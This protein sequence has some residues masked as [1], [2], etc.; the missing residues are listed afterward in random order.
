MSRGRELPGGGELEAREGSIWTP[1]TERWERSDGVHDMERGCNELGMSEKQRTEATAERKGGDDG[2]ATRRKR[3]S[4]AK[5]GKEGKETK[6]RSESWADCGPVIGPSGSILH[7]RFFS[8]RFFLSFFSASLSSRRPF[9]SPP[10]VSRPLQ[11]AP[12]TDNQ[13]NRCMTASHARSRAWSALAAQTS[14]DGHRNCERTPGKTILQ[15]L[16][17]LEMQRENSLGL[18]VHPYSSPDV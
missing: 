13:S 16:R 10:C 14:P 4:E 6:E 12:P 1:G 17:I 8:L 3:A 11:L 7:R 2:M 5:E 15:T 9:I 18:H